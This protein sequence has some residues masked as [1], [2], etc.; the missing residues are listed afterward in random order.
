MQIE[1]IASMAAI[2]PDPKASRGLFVD[3]LRLPLDHN[4][5]DGYYHSERIGGAKHFGVWPLA[6]AAEA[7]FGKP[8]WRCPGVASR[9][10]TTLGSS[11][12]GRRWPDSCRPRA[13]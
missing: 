9:S 3:G 8:E 11:P 5:G 10:C 13:W 2:T 7:C 1:F 12:G 4:E 6:Q